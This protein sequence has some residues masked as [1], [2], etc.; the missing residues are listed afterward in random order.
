MAKSS[1]RS[2]SQSVA[3]LARVTLTPQVRL[4]GKMPRIKGSKPRIPKEKKIKVGNYRPWETA[5]SVLA[6]GF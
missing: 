6:G 1:S 4:T 3:E 2:S 5:Q